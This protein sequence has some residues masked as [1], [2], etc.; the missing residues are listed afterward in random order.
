MPSC[1][2][3]DRDSF[4]NSLCNTVLG[5]SRP[6][7]LCEDEDQTLHR[8]FPTDLGRCCSAP[9]HSLSLLNLGAI[10]GVTA[11]VFGPAVNDKTLHWTEVLGEMLFFLFTRFITLHLHARIEHVYTMQ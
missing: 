7:S 6:P 2:N 11:G 9:I 3:L 5:T 1:L 8:V 4:V 10:I